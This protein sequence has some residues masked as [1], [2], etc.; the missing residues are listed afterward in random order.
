MK[1]I[2][3]AAVF[4]A[5]SL[6]SCEQKTKEKINDASKA[7]GAEVNQK[8]DTVTTK[9]ETAIDSTQSKAGKALQRGAEKMDEA[10]EKLKEAAKK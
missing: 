8:M 5:F 1:K 10:A 2:I 4:M 7:V 9:V 3:L 6:V